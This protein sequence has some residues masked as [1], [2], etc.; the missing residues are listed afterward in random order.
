MADF[1]TDVA[2]LSL[3]LF[4]ALPS[5]VRPENFE[6]KR[7]SHF[8]IIVVGQSH[9]LVVDSDPKIRVG[10]SSRPCGRENFCFQQYC[11]NTWLEFFNGP[12][13]SFTTVIAEPVE[14]DA[15][16]IGFAFT[17]TDLPAKAAD[18]LSCEIRPRFCTNL[19]RCEQFNHL[20]LF[21]GPIKTVR[22]RGDISHDLE[23]SRCGPFGVTFH[24]VAGKAKECVW[25]FTGNMAE[26]EKT[27]G[28]QCTDVECERE[29]Y[30][31]QPGDSTVKSPCADFISWFR[32]PKPTPKPTK[33]ER[34]RTSHK[35]QTTPNTTIFPSLAVRGITKRISGLIQKTDD[36]AKELAARK[37][38]TCSASR[39]FLNIALSPSWLVLALGRFAFAN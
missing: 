5:V 12:P 32:R 22:L 35:Q 36:R 34:S 24:T 37:P 27:V 15:S 18:P 19:T 6:V 26:R 31:F 3:L 29:I 11:G 13:N 2:V 28:L 8:D 23:K 14:R 38:R 17:R 20:M 9:S 7:N 4:L 21:D 25:R 39:S 1:F 33:S 16:P 10:H 30:R